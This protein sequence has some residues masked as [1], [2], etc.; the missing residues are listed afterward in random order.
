MGAMFRKK[1]DLVYSTLQQVQRRMTNQTESG[2][3]QSASQGASRS[4]RSQ[5]EASM[6]SGKL[7]YTGQPQV[8]GQQQPGT[9]RIQSVGGPFTTPQVRRGTDP[10]LSQTGSGAHPIS[11]PAPTSITGG[12]GLMSSPTVTPA[13]ASGNYAQGIL[14]TFPILCVM[15]LLWIVSIIIAYKLG[16]IVMAPSGEQTTALASVERAEGTAGDGPDRSKPRQAIPANTSRTV[17]P[18]RGHDILVLQS[19]STMKAKARQQFERKAKSYNEAARRQPHLLKPYFGV[20]N[21]RNNG[22]QLYFGFKDGNIGV[23][24]ANFPGVKEQMK[25]ANNKRGYPDAYWMTLQ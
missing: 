3:S 15:S 2:Q 24:K 17:H 5:V 12:E 13:G 8:Q 16:P 10:G 1:T 11:A 4:P 21:T 18:A 19:V 14:L 23:K 22:L 7:P 25:G 6:S 20:R 9:E